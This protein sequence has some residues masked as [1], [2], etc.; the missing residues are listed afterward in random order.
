M[1]IYIFL[2]TLSTEWN[3]HLDNQREWVFPLFFGHLWA[4]WFKNCRQFK[5]Q[6]DLSVITAHLSFCNNTMM[7]E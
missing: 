4:M 7:R 1:Y 3:A 5:T 2:F 6:L